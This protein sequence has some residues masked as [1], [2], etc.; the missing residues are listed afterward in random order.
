[1]KRQFKFSKKLIDTLPP[2]PADAGSKEVEYSDQE[3]SGLRLQV[4]RMGRKFFLFRYQIAGRKRSMKVGGYPEVSIDDARQKVIEWRA[5]LI[6]G[7]DPQDQREEQMKASLTFKQFFDDYLWPHVQ[8]TK[9]S[10]KADESRYRNHILP[11]FG[12]REMAKIT[13]LEWQR[14]HNDN[15]TKLAPASANRV[16]EVVRRSYN[17]AC[18]LWDLLPPSANTAKGIKLH[19]E[20]NRRERYLSHEEL[21]RLMPALDTAQNQ[22]MADAFRLLLAT[23]CRKNCRRAFKFDHLCSLNFDQV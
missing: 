3:I 23:G 21:Q 2:C 19:K 17:L 1:M 11:K 16:F 14:F 15:K 20:N 5:L 8:A 9:R 22:M 12:D 13:P 7:I 4:N 6:N 18:G 10:A